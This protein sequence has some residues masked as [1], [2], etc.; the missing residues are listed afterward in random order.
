MRIVCA[1]IQEGVPCAGCRLQR[2]KGCICEYYDYLLLCK[3]RDTRPLRERYLPAKAAL[4]LVLA[5]PTFHISDWYVPFFPLSFVVTMA[6]YSL[7]INLS[8]KISATIHECLW[9]GW[10][11]GVLAFA[12][13]V[14]D[15]FGCRVWWWTERDMTHCDS[16]ATDDGVTAAELSSESLFA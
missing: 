5:I 11:C 14:C 6:T 7:L 10:L 13:M 16:T 2:L 9:C 3:R 4:S 1:V 15:A 8:N 12:R